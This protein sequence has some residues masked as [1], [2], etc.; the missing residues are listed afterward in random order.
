MDLFEVYSSVFV[1]WLVISL[2]SALAVWGY[3]ASHAHGG[4]RRPSHA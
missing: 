4:V 2:L 1:G 3:D